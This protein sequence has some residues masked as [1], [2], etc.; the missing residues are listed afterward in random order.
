[1]R[2]GADLL[3]AGSVAKYTAK[4]SEV[5]CRV[6]QVSVIRQRDDQSSCRIEELFGDNFDARY[7]M[8]LVRS[9]LVCR[10]AVGCQQQQQQQQRL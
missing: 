1:V 2:E 3:C 5:H 9:S 4:F 10:N 8:A 6:G 7:Q